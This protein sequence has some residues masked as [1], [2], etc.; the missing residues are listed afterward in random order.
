MNA[1]DRGHRVKH[2]LLSEARRDIT[3][4]VMMLLFWSFIVLVI[5]MCNKIG[6]HLKN[7]DL[8]LFHLL[9]LLF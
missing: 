1:G 6:F 3:L 8:I 9:Y 4:L 2:F 5:V 7:K